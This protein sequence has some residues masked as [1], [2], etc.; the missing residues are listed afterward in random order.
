[1]EGDHWHSVRR[2]KVG[3]LCPSVRL[4]DADHCA[5][6]R[7][8][9]A[10]STKAEVVPPDIF[11][12]STQIRANNMHAPLHFRARAAAQTARAEENM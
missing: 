5:L 12:A 2:D 4:V 9:V 1:M 6:R 3:H 10:R 8:N 7:G 11:F